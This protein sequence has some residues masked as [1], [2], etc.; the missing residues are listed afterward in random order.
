MRTSYI[1][2]IL[3]A[4]SLKLSAQEKNL[5][6]D[7]QV[8]L[9]Y[10]DL[11]IPAITID[12]QQAIDHRNQWGAR[13]SVPFLFQ[14]LAGENYEE[15]YYSQNYAYRLG[16]FHRYFF[17]SSTLDQIHLRH[18]VRFGHYDLNYQEQGWIPFEDNGNTYYE[19]TT[20]DDNEEV[21]MLGYEL[22]VGWTEMYTNYYF[23]YYAGLSYQNIINYNDL[24]RPKDQAYNPSLL[25]E[26]GTIFTG[27]R[28]IV[29]LIIGL[30][31]N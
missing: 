31:R 3:I 4:L 2:S 17:S 29:G 1:L 6:P 28:P 10:S 30:G 20:R 22:I 18:G 21:L 14:N 16:L 8:G 11:I 26:G 5:A 19:W 12:Y 24:K 15:L 7:W 27:V 13:L 23:E 9:V 25:D